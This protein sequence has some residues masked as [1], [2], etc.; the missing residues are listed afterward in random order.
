MTFGN[1]RERKLSLTSSWVGEGEREKVWGFQR[2]LRIINHIW[3]WFQN[4]T[5]DEQIFFYGGREKIQ[6]HI[7][8]S[9]SFPTPCKIKPQQKKGPTEEGKF[10]GFSSC[11]FQITGSINISATKEKDMFC[12][13]CKFNASL[14]G[15]L[16]F[17]LT[18]VGGG[19]ER[20]E[21]AKGTSINTNDTISSTLWHMIT[22][23]K[24][25]YWK[26]NEPF[27]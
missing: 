7:Y 4:G 10:L 15:A 9:L 3:R 23:L 14:C 2:R 20:E 12:A 13:L 19:R 27:P 1:E 17:A 24:S 16:S 18:C 21:E 22:R 6:K 26:S 5:T 8:L 25:H 11:G